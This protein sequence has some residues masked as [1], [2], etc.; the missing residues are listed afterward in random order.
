M[1]G[2]ASLVAGAGIGAA[3]SYMYQQEQA[4]R[5]KIW[6]IEPKAQEDRPIDTLIN[7]VKGV[8]SSTPA[9]GDAKTS[10]SPVVGEAQPT[11]SIVTTDIAPQTYEETFKD[12]SVVSDVPE[13]FANVYQQRT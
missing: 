6:G 10:S 9:D 13:K 2:F 4:R 3:K 5:D 12:N 11:R 1:S 7:K 8:F